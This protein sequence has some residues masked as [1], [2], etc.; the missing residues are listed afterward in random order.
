MQRP[1]LKHRYEELVSGEEVEFTLPYRYKL[2]IDAFEKLDECIGFFK[3]RSRP[4]LF[5]DLKSNMEQSMRSTISLKQIQ[6]IMHMYPQAYKL[7]WLKSEF[8]SEKYDLQVAVASDENSEQTQSL[9]TSHRVAKLRGLLIE[10]VKYFHSLF[11]ASIGKTLL[12]ADL[13]ASKVWH[14]EFD[15]QALPS[16]EEDPLPLKPFE[17]RVEPLASALNKNVVKNDLLAKLMLTRVQEQ[18]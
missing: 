9:T 13:L 6:Q 7:K 4:T 11:L 3:D 18:Q 8:G 2:L 5:H 16:I 1:S 15:L 10:R 17:L 14:S 12:E